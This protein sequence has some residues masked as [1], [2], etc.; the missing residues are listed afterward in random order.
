MMTLTMFRE[1]MERL[2]N[3]VTGVTAIVIV[4]PS[5]VI[6]HLTAGP[7][8]DIDAFAGEYAT[9]LRIARRTSDD[10]GTGDLLEHIVVSE[11]SVIVARHISSDYFLILVAN[12]RDQLG[13]A[14]YELK[15]V[16]S[17]MAKIL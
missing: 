7:T 1:L 8:L 16:S 4:G 6:E 12:D 9:L 13:R 17:D 14:R 11:K 2:R 15:K 3:K 10:A 5:G